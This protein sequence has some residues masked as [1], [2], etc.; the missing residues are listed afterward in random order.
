M[1][2]GRFLAH[3]DLLVTKDAGQSAEPVRQQLARQLHGRLHRRGRRPRSSTQSF[4]D[5]VALFRSLS[6]ASTALHACRQLKE[7][8]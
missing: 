5:R 4:L 2:L 3:L 1:D 7:R 6:L 8:G